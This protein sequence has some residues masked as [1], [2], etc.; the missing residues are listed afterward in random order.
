MCAARASQHARLSTH[1]P[2]ARGAHGTHGGGEHGRHSLP[3]A[4]S[5]QD[6]YSASPP[7]APPLSPRARRR[8][9][10]ASASVPSSPRARTRGRGRDTQA[11]APGVLLGDD[12]GR[13]A[14]GQEHDEEGTDEV[15]PLR[16]TGADGISV[17]DARA[18]SNSSHI[19]E[20]QYGAMARHEDFL[21]QDTRP[22]PFLSVKVKRYVR[23]EGTR[24]SLSKA[25]D[26][27]VIWSFDIAGAHVQTY[28]DDRKISVWLTDSMRTR[29]RVIVLCAGDAKQYVRWCFWLRRASLSVLEMHYGMTRLI[30]KGA[31]A[32]VVLAKDLHTG[33]DCAIKLIEKSNAPP[34]A[35]RYMQR[36]VQIMRLVSHQNIVKCLDIFDSRL[37]TR[38][39]MEYMGGGMLSEAIQRSG[40][41]I[42]ES[43]AR[44]IIHGILSGVEY[45]HKSGIVH[46]DLKPDNC[47]LPNSEEPYGD[48]KLSDFGLSNFV[49][50]GEPYNGRLASDES[51]LTSA[52][53][54][55]GFVAPELFEISYGSAVDLWSVG[56]ITYNVLT[57]EM[58]FRGNTTEDV[59][60]AARTGVI[61]FATDNARKLSPQA[62]NLISALLTVDVDA[63]PTAT[64]AL[65]H[66]WFTAD[67]GSDVGPSVSAGA[68]SEQLKTGN[69]SER[70]QSDV[71]EIA[72]DEISAVT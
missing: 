21:R 16:L 41:G 49:P 48:V 19:P 18:A 43:A 55:P 72:H 32:R 66:E 53:G 64:Q 61:H 39:V 22:V 27:E 37:R 44:G 60:R 3:R 8:G 6:N 63:R 52:V 30:N 34:S 17:M 12:I 59:V 1:Q 57:A 2:R 23:L 33:R 4:R 58:P 5:H 42:P 65:Q 9:G 25:A 46:R 54:S 15:P 71:R 70:V 56:V 62:R 68:G 69:K 47:L 7:P 11:Q 28:D 45:L 14:Q 51:V 35:R 50:A 29:R 31:F 20:L 26:G 38:I 67:K 10:F 24:L 36:E 40:T 13:R